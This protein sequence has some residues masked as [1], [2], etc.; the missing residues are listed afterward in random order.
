MFTSDIDTERKHVLRHAAASLC[1]ALLCAGFGAVYEHFSFGV[2]SYFMIYA[3]IYPLAAGILLLFAAMRPVLPQPR[4]L[5]LLHAAAAA[6]TVGSIAAGIIKISGRNHGLL[7]VY[8][9]VGGLLTILAV[10]SYLH[11]RKP[12]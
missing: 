9:I 4:T 3:F 11:D 5:F 10:I 8:P 2:Y 12:Q 1:A 6:C 7:I